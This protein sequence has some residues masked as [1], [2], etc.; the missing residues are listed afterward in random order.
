MIQ[1]G[2]RSPDGRWVWNG[3]AWVPAPPPSRGGTA[4][5]VI[6]LVAGCI[7]ILV[8]T[9][10]VVIVILLFLLY[11]TWRIFFGLSGDFAEEL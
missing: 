10:I 4:G 3:T 6:G 11:A 5:V 1:P 9:S 2:Q 7:G 8:L